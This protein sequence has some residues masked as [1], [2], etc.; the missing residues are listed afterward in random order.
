MVP[1]LVSVWQEV[2]VEGEVYEDLP[3]PAL[4]GLLGPGD[5]E[6]VGVAALLPLLPGGGHLPLA[7][8]VV[9]ARTHHSVRLGGRDI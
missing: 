2:P 1:L 7:P 5:G 8:P 3:V 4:P 6:V 9:E